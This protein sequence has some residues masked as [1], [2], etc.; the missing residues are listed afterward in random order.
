MAMIFHRARWETETRW[1]EAWITSDL[2]G[3][4]IL[5]RH[6]GAKASKHHGQKT[7][8]CRDMED[9]LRR[10]SKLQARRS[11]RPVPYARVM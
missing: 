11:G 6:W 7:I 8:L 2:F 3:D 4:V 5:V 1:Y 10:L 9:A